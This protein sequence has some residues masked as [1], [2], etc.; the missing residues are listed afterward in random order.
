ML[1]PRIFWTRKEKEA[2]RQRE[3]RA[4]RET[5]LL[6]GA[7]RDATGDLVTA[8]HELGHALAALEVGHKLEFVNIKRKVLSIEE[9][10]KDGLDPNSSYLVD[11]HFY[12]TSEPPTKSTV[13]RFAFVLMSGPTS[14]VLCGRSNA[15]QIRKG[16]G[17]DDAALF[18]QCLRVGLSKEE[19]SKIQAE[20]IL[21]AEIFLKKESTSAAIEELVPLLVERQR[22]TGGEVK[23]VFDKYKDSVE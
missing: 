1:K 5:E 18:D 14:E 19:S 8:Y 20:Q 11:G 17:V 3:V 9:I 13:W 15:E 2:E 4:E 12:A 10:K 21:A 23:A 16:R 6:S 22:L 7:S